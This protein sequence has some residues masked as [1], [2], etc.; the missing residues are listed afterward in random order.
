MI[1]SDGP[2]AT[3]IFTMSLVGEALGEGAH[4]PGVLS[5]THGRSGYVQ[6]CLQLLLAASDGTGANPNFTT[7]GHFN[8]KKSHQHQG[9]AIRRVTNRL[10]N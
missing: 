7:C 1:T 10:G 6:D 3:P 8:L 5:Q 4:C 9:Y 2:Q